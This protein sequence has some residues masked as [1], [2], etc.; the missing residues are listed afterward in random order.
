MIAM[1]NTINCEVTLI[2][3]LIINVQS[4]VFLVKKEQKCQFFI[5]YYHDKNA[6]SSF[7]LSYI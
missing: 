5:L 6:M 3:L 1:K 7:V 2:L 4:I